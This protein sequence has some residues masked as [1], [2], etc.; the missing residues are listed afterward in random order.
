[1]TAYVTDYTYRR[2]I[3][4]LYGLRAIL[5]YLHLVSIYVG[6]SGLAVISL[7]KV[8][9]RILFDYDEELKRFVSE[10]GCRD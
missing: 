10:L 5:T 3:L 8:D 9:S 7:Q 2:F 6:S 4:F 1:M